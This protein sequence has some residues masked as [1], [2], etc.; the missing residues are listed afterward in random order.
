MVHSNTFHNMDGRFLLLTP[1]RYSYHVLSHKEKIHIWS[2]VGEE[3]GDQVLTVTLE[4]VQYHSFRHA[5][6]L[7]TD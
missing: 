4:Q 1:P 2:A 6:A 5:K 3:S 7:D